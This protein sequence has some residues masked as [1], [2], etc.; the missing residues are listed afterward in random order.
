MSVVII[1]RG[2]NSRSV[3]S[4]GVLE[5]IV[6]SIHRFLWGHVDSIRVASIKICYHFREGDEQIAWV[7][8]GD[9]SQSSLEFPDLAFS[10][11]IRLVMARLSHNV[12]DSYSLGYLF[13]DGIGESWVSITD[14]RDSYSMRLKYMVLESLSSLYCLC[15][16]RCWT[17]PAESYSS[18]QYQQDRILAH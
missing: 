6:S 3:D 8:V 13:P 12:I 4:V 1:V 14:N 2:R 10:L 17:Q 16:N 11:P 5:G 18:I 7:E 15:S 9:V